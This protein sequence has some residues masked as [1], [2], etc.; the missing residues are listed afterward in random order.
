LASLLRKLLR[1]GSISPSLLLKLRKSRV[2]RA[3]KVTR[4]RRT[5]QVRQACVTVLYYRQISS[6]H[7]VGLGHQGVRLRSSRSLPRLNLR[8][9]RISIPLEARA[10]LPVLRGFAQ[11]SYPASHGIHRRVVKPS[12]DR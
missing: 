4:K 12:V 1:S 5:G 9:R 10:N 7:R 11:F 2:G 8:R 6:I 3:A